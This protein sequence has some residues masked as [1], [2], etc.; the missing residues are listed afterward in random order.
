MPK[1]FIPVDN[2]MGPFRNHRGVVENQYCA[3]ENLLKDKNENLSIKMPELNELRKELR[4]NTQY[5]S[6]HK[7]YYSSKWYF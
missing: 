2:I 5:L 7:L 1:N 3:L 4:Y 6:A